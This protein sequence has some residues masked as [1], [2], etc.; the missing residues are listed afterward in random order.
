MTIFPTKVEGHGF[1]SHRVHSA[2]RDFLLRNIDERNA[3][4]KQKKKT[5]KKHKQNPKDVVVV[6]VLTL[7][8]HVRVESRQ[9]I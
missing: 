6:V 4:N 7:T 8:T 5:R 2:R 1:K 3:R 9:K